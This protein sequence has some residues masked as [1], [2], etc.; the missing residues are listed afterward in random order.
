MFLYRAEERAADI[1][2]IP[3]TRARERISLQPLSHPTKTDRDCPRAVPHREADQ[4]LVPEQD[5]EVE[6]GEQIQVR[7]PRP[8]GFSRL[9]LRWVLLPIQRV[10]SDLM[11]WK[12]QTEAK[13]LLKALTAF[14]GFQKYLPVCKN[15]YLAS[16]KNIQ[17]YPQL[18]EPPTTNVMMEKFCKA[19]HRDFSLSNLWLGFSYLVLIFFKYVVSFILSLQHQLMP[20]YIESK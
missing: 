10:Y 15:N 14:Y 17:V 18:V 1:H 13:Y 4:D 16:D 8:G 3:N 9:K 7:R 20:D 2:A 6:E 12:L 11:M 5:D 19:N